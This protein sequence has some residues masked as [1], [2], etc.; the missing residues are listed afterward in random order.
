M[1]VN[2]HFPIRLMKKLLRVRLNIDPCDRD[3]AILMHHDG[4]GDG[5]GEDLRDDLTIGEVLQENAG[6]KE[7]GALVLY[8]LTRNV[9]K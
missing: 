3:V 1:M 7:K 6:V 9:V 8:F 5:S 4:A 2:H